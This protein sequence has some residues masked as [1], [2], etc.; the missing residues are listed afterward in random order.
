MRCRNCGRDE[1]EHLDHRDDGGGLL[2]MQLVGTYQPAT[3]WTETQKMLL[4]VIVFNAVVG[5]LIW[6]RY[7]S[8]WAWGE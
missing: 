6:L 8:P 7:V 3:T 1:A 5:G 2:C 4:A